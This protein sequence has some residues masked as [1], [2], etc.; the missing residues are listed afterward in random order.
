[1]ETKQVT[2]T[3]AKETHELGQGLVKFAAALKQAL[4]DGFQAGSDVPVILSSAMMDLIP[5]VNGFELISEESKSTKEF[6]NAAY[7]SVNELY[8]TLA[9]KAT[10]SV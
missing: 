7:L 9:K 6:A 2:V 10:P 8:F 5:A 1:M 3:V 4:A